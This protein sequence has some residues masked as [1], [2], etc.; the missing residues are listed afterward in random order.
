MICV[1]EF[2]RACGDWL[3]KS[4]PASIRGRKEEIWGGR[5]ASYANPDAKLWLDR[6]AERGWTVPSWPKEYGG[7]GLAP[8]ETAVLQEEMTRRGCP[9]PLFDFGISLLGPIL[10]EFGSEDQKREF[11]PRIA[12]GEIRW[13]QGFS[14]PGAG[15]DLA[16]LQCRAE[17]D[18]DRYR[19]TGHKVWTSFGA[20]ADWIFCLVRTDRDAPKRDG[21]SFLLIDMESDGVSTA[22]MELISGASRFSEVFLEDVLVPVRNRVGEENHGWPIARRLLAI[23]RAA[24]SEAGSAGILGEGGGP[25]LAELARTYRE[26]ADPLLRDEIA[27]AEMDRLA[28]R[29]ALARPRNGA[30]D[31]VARASFLK[32]YG[33]ELTKRR[34]DLRAR[35]LGA[36]GL[37]WEG[38][39]F[40]DEEV[41][42]VRN[43]LWSRGYSIL[44][45]TSEIQLNVIARRGLRLPT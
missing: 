9:E 33:T 6:M 14:E 4:C 34:C 7:A 39:V 26:Q 40:S 22:P 43:W 3:E 44:G 16:S 23:E 2:R 13:C 10:L 18:G 17:R 24:I 31:A 25:R 27:R 11:L 38:E 32:Y 19:V 8:E 42:T 41:A 35:I 5:K 30:L 45:G 29:A 12:R 21:I 20:Q 37:G 15:S 28:Y 1:K 36:Q